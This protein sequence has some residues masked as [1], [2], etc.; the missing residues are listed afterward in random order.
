MGLKDGGVDA[1]GRIGGVKPLL[2]AH[3]TRGLAPGRRPGGAARDDGAGGAPT[4]AT[5]RLP[6]DN[7]EASRIEDIED[8]QGGLEI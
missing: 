5:S 3:W 1:G 8:M 7:E 6:L 2:L 4:T